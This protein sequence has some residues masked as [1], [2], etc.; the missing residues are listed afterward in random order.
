MADW[1]LTNIESYDIVKMLHRGLKLDVV[2]VV[3]KYIK[4]E[5]EEENYL[6]FIAS[7][8]DDKHTTPFTFMGKV[9]KDHINC[10]PY[11]KKMPQREL[12]SLKY[13]IYTRLNA[14]VMQHYK[15]QQTTLL[16]FGLKQIKLGNVSKNFDV[17]QETEQN[18]KQ[19]TILEV[20]DM[21]NRSAE[22]Q[23]LEKLHEEYTEFTNFN[24]YEVKVEQNNRPEIHFEATAES[25]DYDNAQL[26][27]E[28][29]YIPD[30]YLIKGVKSGK[31][32]NATVE[33]MDSTN[34]DNSGLSV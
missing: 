6:Q 28:G 25:V 27:E 30:V 8:I 17:G 22:K 23:I 9:Y 21:T 32:F 24:L 1:F 7:C 26:D 14:G 3:L 10:S 2:D 34:E 16:D 13:K 31:Y 12:S 33:K 18:L 11:G 4:N 5:N 15:K 19:K 29:N 20:E